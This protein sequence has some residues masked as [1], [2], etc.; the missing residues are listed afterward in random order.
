M[1]GGIGSFTFDAA[2]DGLIRPTACGHD[3]AHNARDKVGVEAG[4][5]FLYVFKA[6]LQRARRPRRPSAG[7]PASRIRG[8]QRVNSL[9]TLPET[10]T[11]QA[12]GIIQTFIAWRESDE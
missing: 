12:F 1:R 11:I 6:H 4:Y 5:K 3:L 8:E 7:R 10:N 9:V 2:K